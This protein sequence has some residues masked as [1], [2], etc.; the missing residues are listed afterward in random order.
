[1]KKVVTLVLA[2]I[3]VLAS[4]SALA[5]YDKPILFRGVEWGVTHNEAVK[6]LPAEL[7]WWALD[8]SSSVYPV[9]H[10][11]Y[12]EGR[13]Y[14]N[15]EVG[16]Y[17]SPRSSSIGKANLTVAGYAVDDV[18]LRYAFIPNADGT[19]SKSSDT[20]KLYYAY[21]KLDPKDPDAAYADL[22]TKLTTLYGDPDRSFTKSPYISYEYT[23]WYGADDTVLCLEREDYPSGSHYIYIKYAT[24][25]GNEWLSTAYDALVYEETKN[26]GSN[27]DGL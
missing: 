17:V 25:K 12:D 15:G 13:D 4:T 27:L 8:V 24:L 9:E 11:L 16:G 19:L 2:L 26:A 23:I 18:T 10:A 7:N 3:M 6:S 1:M 21:Y 5:Q 22:T 20:A 14:F